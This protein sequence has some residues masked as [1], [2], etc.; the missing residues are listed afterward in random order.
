MNNNELIESN[1]NLTYWYLN[2]KV[3]KMKGIELEEY[4][5][6]LHIALVKACN[7][8]DST[9]GIKFATYFCT[10]ARNEIG[11]LHRYYA[12]Y[13]GKGIYTVSLSEPIS[14]EDTDA[15]LEDIVKN[16]TDMLE[17]ALNKET[18]KHIVSKAYSVDK[19]SFKI[20]YAN[21]ICNIPQRVIAIKLGIKQSTVCKRI[22]TFNKKLQ[23]IVKEC[24]F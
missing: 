19:S 3:T 13:L 23:K 20:W 9:K 21:K 2:N 16:E 14:Q 17:D 12:K 5:S 11:M 22:A 24:Y 1:I 4:I 8:Y 18:M 15:T 6:I 10:V 7:T